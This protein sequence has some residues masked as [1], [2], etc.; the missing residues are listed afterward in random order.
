MDIKQ[1]TSG[2]ETNKPEHIIEAANALFKKLHSTLPKSK[3]EQM[4]EVISEEGLA[5]VLTKLHLV[6]TSKDHKIKLLDILGDPNFLYYAWCKIMEKKDKSPGLDEVPIQNVGI[7]TLKSLSKE[8]LSRKYKPSP[9]KRIYIEKANGQ[10]RPL[11]IPTSR[12]KIVQQAL[13]I[14]IEPLFEPLFST[15]SHG[16]RPNRSCH[17]ALQQIKR[18]WRMVSYFINLDLEK[19][20][21][22]LGH[23]QIIVALK[24]HC[25]DKDIL[26]VVYAMLKSGY[27]NLT[28]SR[29]TNMGP[30]E[31]I[32]QGSIISPLLSNIV[33]NEFDWTVE[34]KLIPK[35]SKREKSSCSRM[36]KEYY[37]A[38]RKFDTNDYFL[39]DQIKETMGLSTRQARE[40]IQSAKVK[41]AQKDG[42]EYS[43]KNETTERLWYVRYADDFIFG[44]VGPKTKALQL[45]SEIIYELGYIGVG[46]NSEKSVVAHHSKGISFLSYNIFGKY[47]LISGSKI[48]KRGQRTIRTE[49]AFSAPIKKLMGR[50]K[51]RGFVMSNRR[52]KVNS[53]LVARR[54]DKWIFLQPEEIV[55]RYRSIMTALIHYYQGCQQ[56][57]DLYEVL[58]IYKRSCAITLAHHHK[59]S[60]YKKVIAKYGDDLTVHYK[61]KSGKAL[62]VDCAIPSLEGGGRFKTKITKDAFPQSIE[63]ALG[64]PGSLVPKSLHELKSASELMCHIP[65]CP[66]QAQEWHHV[67]HR[68]NSKINTAAK[69]THVALFAK[70]IPIC[71]EHHVLI[72]SG[73]YNGPSLIKMKGYNAGDWDLFKK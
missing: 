58:W 8:L 29:D 63:Q 34:N 52:G 72:H 55:K 39:R 35:Y 13:K 19:F 68:K 18:E 17:T 48:H 40:V 51:E 44:Y 9:A 30:K 12:D 27:V 50:A 60:S 6:H 56:R 66:N 32:P 41:V 15:N 36:S 5:V 2:F 3:I 23:K 33:L 54:C 71:K 42:V 65:N 59:F 31:S 4:V 69:Q 24:R 26:T 49:V 73:K 70:Q 45:T 38:T 57:S 61:S 53:K 16:F 28:N 46:I 62:T 14:I 7:R 10:K 37:E 47:T 11:G 22:K 25:S 20:F 64:L 21:D 43:M 67:K 1:I